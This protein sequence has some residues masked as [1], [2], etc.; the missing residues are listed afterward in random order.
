L[1]S[2]GRDATTPTAW[3][4]AVA[5]VLPRSRVVIIPAMT[6]LPVG[7]ANMVCLDRIMD[8]FFA[9]GSAEGLDISCIE[10]MTPPPFG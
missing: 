2:G 4:E 10:T 7:L 8:A 9:K 5:A 3:A 1:M 6:H